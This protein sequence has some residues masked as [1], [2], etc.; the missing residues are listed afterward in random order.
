M[1]NT[2][3]RAK[4]CNIDC[5]IY[6]IFQQP[7]N[8]NNNS[9]PTQNVN[10]SINNKQLINQTLHTAQKEVLISS[11]IFFIELYQHN[12]YLTP[13][14][15]L[16]S[17]PQKSVYQAAHIWCGASAPMVLTNNTTCAKHL[18]LERRQPTEVLIIRRRPLISEDSHLTSF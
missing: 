15:P 13:M 18:Y 14:L 4:L 6:L 11:R 12:L 3:K 16:F 5:K 2:F 1:K 7:Q 17:I 9:N 10:L 8:D